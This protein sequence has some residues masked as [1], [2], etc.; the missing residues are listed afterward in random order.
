MMDKKGI[1]RLTL[2][3]LIIGI[4]TFAILL[5]LITN[6]IYPFIFSTTTKESCRTSVLLR[7]W[8][9]EKEPAVTEPIFR[10]N[11]INCKTEYKCLTKGGECPEKYQKIKVENE[12]D[13]KAEIA[14]SMYDCWWMLGEGRA[15]FIGDW[16]KG[17][18]KGDLGSVRGWVS[19]W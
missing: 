14:G 6:V 18:Y 4:I 7:S 12:E 19:L 3:N 2:M 9:L 13:M 11:P 15:E 1:I 10:A 16:E 5:F 17:L 8:I